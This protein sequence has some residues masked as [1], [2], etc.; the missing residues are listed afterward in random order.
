MPLKL[1]NFDV[2][3]CR[4]DSNGNVLTFL[5]REVL[6]YGYYGVQ[7]YT[8]QEIVVVSMTNKGILNWTAVVPRH[9]VDCYKAFGRT[10]KLDKEYIHIL[11]TESINRMNNTHVYRKVYL[12]NGMASRAQTPIEKLKKLNG[13]PFIF[14]NGGTY[15]IVGIKRK[16]RVLE[17][18][19]P[20]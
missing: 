3:D 15:S 7:I 18:Y 10:I 14:H 1:R 5:T 17:K 11:M 9:Y 4:I 20:D 12:S 19:K 8:A 16:K 2:F 13:T 6:S